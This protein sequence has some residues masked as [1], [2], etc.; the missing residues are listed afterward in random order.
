[1]PLTIAHPAAVL[2]FKRSGLPLSAL[3]IGSMAPD[4]EYWLHLSPH[5]DI[6]HSIL[7]LF[8]FC[9]PVGMLALWVFHR[10][11]KQPLAA[12]LGGGYGHL[13]TPFPFWPFPRFIMLCCEILIGALT[14]LIW[15][16]FTHQYGWAVQQVTGLSRPIQVGYIEV[17][18]YK[19]LQHASTLLGCGILLF[20]AFYRRKWKWTEVTHHWTVMVIVGWLTIAGGVALGMLVAGDV[21]SFEGLKR[22]VGCGLVV[23][24]L[25]MTL[26][27]TFLCMIWHIRHRPAK[28]IPL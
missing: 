27:T 6:S 17:P 11:W 28:P 16:S 26:V 13:A 9:L 10:I 20:V 24:S 23:G 21:S 7:G 3:V 12:M 25:I 2:P 8:T 15:D 22:W 4:F 1:M 14:H 18:L 19:I 5:S